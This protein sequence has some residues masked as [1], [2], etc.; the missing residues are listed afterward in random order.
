MITTDVKA[1]ML[2]RN[3]NSFPNEEKQCEGR[4]KTMTRTFRKTYDHNNKSGNDR[5]ECAFMD[6]LVN[7]YGADRPNVH[8]VA[9]SS[10]HP[11]KN[12]NQLNESDVT[13]EE[14]V[15]NQPKKKNLNRMSRKRKR[16]SKQ[17]LRDRILC[18]VK[19]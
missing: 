5:R 13:D 3:L 4:W 16:G 15:G 6:E 1:E 10:S 9:T 7:A 2:K 18:I 19:K 8:L 17:E 14:E 12:L 11:T